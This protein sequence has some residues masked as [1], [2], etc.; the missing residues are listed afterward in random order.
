MPVEQAVYQLRVAIGG[1]LISVERFR[2]IDEITVGAQYSSVLALNDSEYLANKIRWANPFAPWTC[3]AS[4][5]T[6]PSRSVLVYQSNLLELS[7]AQ[8]S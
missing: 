6:S 8:I 3:P 1:D 7:R 2:E 4:V 5:D